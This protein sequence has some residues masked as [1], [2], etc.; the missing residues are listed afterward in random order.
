[1]IDREQLIKFIPKPK[2]EDI[3]IYDTSLKDLLD[4]DV[5][6]EYNNLFPIYLNKKEEYLLL[7][8]RV[9]ENNNTINNIYL[10]NTS[11]S[12]ED[13]L[14]KL[15]NDKKTYN[16]IYNDIKRIENNIEI[17]Q[18]KISV[19]NEK[20][21]I[22][23]SKDQKKIEEKRK[24]IDDNIQ[25]NKNNLLQLKDKL[26]SY[27]Q[28]YL[29][30]EKQ[31][32][33]N[34][35]EFNILSDMQQNLKTG[36]YK[37]KYCGSTVKVYSEN[38]LIYKR[39]EKNLIENKKD[40][41]NLLN[42]KNDIELNI[43]YYENEISKIK[44]ELNNDIEFKKQNYNFYNKKSIDVL[45]LEALRDELM[46]N[47]SQK[48]KE[49]KSKSS[50]K[51]DKYINLKDDIEKCE[52]SLEN[53]KKIKEIKLEMNTIIEEYKKSKEEIT[54]IYNKIKKYV[55]FLIIYYKVLEQKINDFFGKDYNFKLMKFDELILKPTLELKYK[56]I[57][58]SE[59]DKKNK[60]EV[61]SNLS[62]KI[63]IFN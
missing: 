34:N 6:Q 39:L 54:I 1:M 16:T 57:N 50:I 47:L 55:D 45:K 59:L 56:G 3:I 61:D 13:Y 40:L 52:L 31:I 32:N 7:K 37:C 21:Q 4:I 46:N 18:K 62:L 58:Y 38:S 23:I 48:E 30:I 19:M 51:T 63:S 49:L 24:N 11:W 43:A 20:I 26:S 28:I 44:S 25:K 35:D 8:S 29:L 42:K 36:N 22:Q 33:E 2:N 27:K 12:E 41:E 17:L 5:I 60:E 53:L 15:K 9:E 10:F 14:Y